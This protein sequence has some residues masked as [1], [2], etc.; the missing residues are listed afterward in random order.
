MR[1]IRGSSIGIV[2]S[3]FLVGFLSLAAVANEAEIQPEEEYIKTVNLTKGEIVVWDWSSND[4]PID[5][6]II[7]PENDTLIE[8]ND[9]MASNDTFTTTISGNWSF[10]WANNHDPSQT[11]DY[12]T[13]LNYNITVLNSPPTAII[14]ADPNSGVIPISVDFNGIGIDND[15]EIISYHW[16]LGD[17]T[18]SESKELTHNYTSPGIYEV[19][20]TVTDDDGA[21]NF[22]LINITAYPKTPVIVSTS[23]EDGALDITVDTTIEIEFSILMDKSDVENKIT[24]NPEVG[25]TFSWS[26]ED[27]NITLIFDALSYGTSYTLHIGKANSSDGGLMEDSKSIGFITVELPK[28]PSIQI[29]SPDPDA[30]FTKG[31][32]IVIRGT[33]TDIEKGEKINITIGEETFEAIVGDGGN[34]STEI[35]APTDGLLT[36]TAKYGEVQDDVSVEIDKEEEGSSLLIWII[37]IV[38][39]VL[40]AIILSIFL[41]KKKGDDEPSEPQFEPQPEYSEEAYNANIDS[42]IDQGVVDEVQAEDELYVNNSLGDSYSAPVME[43]DVTGIEED[44]PLSMSEPPTDSE[45]ALDDYGISDD[46]SYIEGENESDV[47]EADETQNGMI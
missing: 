34:W 15:G 47:V 23:I 14:E 12:S 30:T 38:L 26:N 7:D 43:D 46:I 17:G 4:Q 36:I 41:L 39:V 29:T 22:T 27:K 13:T 9:A 1:R 16:D 2:L 10:Y 20:L 24:I 37:I 6:W 8:I 3:M 45:E 35:E 25:I 33:S 11:I 18:T 19:K 31:D 5:F 28:N 32:K 42:S 40:T 44:Q 21:T